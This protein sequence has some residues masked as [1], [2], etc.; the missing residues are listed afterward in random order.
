MS[1]SQWNAGSAWDARKRRAGPDLNQLDPAARAVVADCYARGGS[2]EEAWTALNN[3]AWGEPTPGVTTTGSAQ[4]TPETGSA[5]GASAMG[6]AQDPK[7]FKRLDPRSTIWPEAPHKQL[8]EVYRL[9][10]TFP[11]LKCMTSPG[12]GTR[13]Q[14]IERYA[15]IKT[16]SLVFELNATTQLWLGSIL[17]RNDLPTLDEHG[18][19]CSFHCLP[20]QRSIICIDDDRTDAGQ[21]QA[22]MGL[23]RLFPMDM[24][25]IM[26]M[27]FNGAYASASG[28]GHVGW[29][30]GQFAKDI[31]LAEKA[32][33]DFVSGLELLDNFLEE[34][35]LCPGVLRVGSDSFASLCCWLPVGQVEIPRLHEARTPGRKGHRALVQDAPVCRIRPAGAAG[36]RA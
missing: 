32:E 21:Y 3:H 16:M 27:S 28:Q 36:P 9:D 31:E 17:A 25:N 7:A 6:S 2:I 8:Q 33:E 13:Q 10:G 29:A 14:C 11:L 35:G 1:W 24:A 12:D 22:T 30:S 15:A 26:Q 20:T 4:V 5:Q 18:I 34:K 23:K 19:K